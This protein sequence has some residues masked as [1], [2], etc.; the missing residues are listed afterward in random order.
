MQGVYK[1]MTDD[2][3]KEWCFDLVQFIFSKYGSEK[4]IN[5]IKELLYNMQIENDNI[6]ERK[7]NEIINK[8]NEFLQNKPKENRALLEKIDIFKSKLD[9]KH[10]RLESFFKALDEY[11]TKRF[12]SDIYIFTNGHNDSYYNADFFYGLCRT[13][14]KYKF[15]L[16]ILKDLKI[17][18]KN[19][20]FEED[21]NSNFSDFNN[22][23]ELTRDYIRD[24]NATVRQ[25]SVRTTSTEKSIIDDLSN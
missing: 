5:E 25:S 7:L 24:L 23:Y 11:I 19:T 9:D 1:T 15:L 18:S 3:R 17:I 8:Y 21:F 2:Q 22:G 14:F 16:S 20:T 10:N 12:H 4:E 6:K 13:P